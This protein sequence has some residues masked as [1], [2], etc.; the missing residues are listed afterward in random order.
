MEDYFLN[1]EVAC[2]LGSKA[3]SIKWGIPTLQEQSGASYS[4]PL[5]MFSYL[6]NLPLTNASI[7]LCRVVIVVCCFSDHK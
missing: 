5:S 4:Q 3:V 1:L 6:K 2:Q 7:E